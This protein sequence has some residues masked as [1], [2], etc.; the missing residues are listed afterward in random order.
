MK[1]FEKLLRVAR[2]KAAFDQ[3]NPWYSGS[4]TYLAAIRT[5]LD[6]VVEE[7]PKQRVCFLEDELADL[8]WNYLNILQALEKEAGIDSASVI[9]RA[10]RKYEER[11]TGIE[12]GELWQ[13]IKEK[14][15]R[16]LATEQELSR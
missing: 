1:D 3:T 10:Y 12:S 5:E 7:I 8:L 4:E 9:S 13:E 6:E 15:K 11:I 2:R 14:Q 16:A